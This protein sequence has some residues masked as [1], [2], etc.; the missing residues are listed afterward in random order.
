MA[1]K[2]KSKA[3]SA[4]PAP[5]PVDLGEVRARIDS[6][7][8]KIQGLLNERAHFTQIHRRWRGQR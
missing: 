2:K 8:E 5:A 6:V 1:R 3:S 4:L 7:D